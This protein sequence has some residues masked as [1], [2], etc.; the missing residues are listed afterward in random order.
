MNFVSLFPLARPVFKY[1]R[2]NN[3]HA[4]HNRFPGSVLTWPLHRTNCS[5]C[6]F[7]LIS[8]SNDH[9]YSLLLH[10]VDVSLFFAIFVL[11]AYAACCCKLQVPTEKKE[12]AVAMARW[13]CLCTGKLLEQHFTTI[14]SFKGKTRKHERDVKAL[15]SKNHIC[16]V[17]STSCNYLRARTRVAV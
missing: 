5:R 16:S 8:G 4:S 15:I 10:C 3:N 12:P 14:M 7:P 1:K 17:E 11:T 2:H 9:S 13:H 6:V